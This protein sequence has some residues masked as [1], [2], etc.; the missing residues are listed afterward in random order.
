MEP[1][2]GREFGR[3]TVVSEPFRNDDGR[4]MVEALCEC[5]TRR[6]LR[7][8]G[9]LYGGSKSCGCSLRA[10]VRRNGQLKGRRCGECEDMSWRRPRRRACSCGE[11]YA[12][13]KIPTLEDILE[14]PREDRRTM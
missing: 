11:T 1:W 12:A 10:A 5:G 13:E 7:P 3:W 9:L 14:R 8:R 4:L 6:A 2:T